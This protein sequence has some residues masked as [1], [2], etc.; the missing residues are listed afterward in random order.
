MFAS[1]VVV[2]S[3]PHEGGS[4]LIR[5]KD[6]EWTF[7]SGKELSLLPTSSAGYVAF[8]SDVEHEVTPVTAG[9]RITLTYNLYLEQNPPLIVQPALATT[10]PGYGT[11]K[12]AI[13]EILADSSFLPEG[14]RIGFGLSHQ[15][16]YIQSLTGWSS[17]KRGKQETGQLDVVR[18]CLKGMDS[19]L[20]KVCEELGLK[21]TVRLVYEEWGTLVLMSRIVDLEGGQIDTD[22]AYVLT[23]DYK[24]EV[25]QAGEDWDEEV[26]PK[27]AVH[28]VTPRNDFNKVKA[29]YVSYGNEAQAAHIY[30][31]MCLIVEIG[32]LG[33]RKTV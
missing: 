29:D 31:E 4:L 25:I 24:G 22:I 7:D 30:G 5:H 16:P 14:G 18:S 1:L 23:Q 15:Y 28:W 33:D 6:Q 21:A 32:G 10:K 2:F 12:T 17:W 27:L 8:Y 9:H 13:Q 3:T 20:H 11:L 26:D 19:T